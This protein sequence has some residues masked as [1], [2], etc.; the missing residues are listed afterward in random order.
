V[1]GS[2]TLGQGVVLYGK[3]R[4]ILQPYINDALKMRDSLVQ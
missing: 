4:A 3:V 2:K 1:D